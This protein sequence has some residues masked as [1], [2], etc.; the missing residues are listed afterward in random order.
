VT[1][2]LW[3]NESDK[4]VQHLRIIDMTVM[5]TGP[6]LTRVLVQ[7]GADVIKVEHLPHGD[8]LR[9]KKNSG[10]FE[11][12]NQ[13]KR[14]LALNLGTIEATMVMKQLVNEADIFIEN[15]KEGVMDG[16][17]LGYDDLSEENPDLL[18]LSLRGFSGNRKVR[19]GHD[20]NF[21]ATSGCGDFFLESGPHYSTQFADIVGGVSIPLIKLLFQLA[22]PR[23]KGKHIVSNNDESFRFLYLPRAYDHFK[24]EQLPP[25]EK[26]EFGW[27]TVLGGDEPHS[28]Y[29][30]CRDDKW[31]ALN[32]VQKNHWEKFCDVV[33]KSD[34]KNRLSDPNLTSEMQKLFLDAPSTYWE[35][36][37]SKNEICLTK[38]VSWDELIAS[39]P[40][41]Q[42]LEGD[43]LTW[44][45]LTP[46][47]K[48]S[49]APVLGRDTLSITQG[50][51]FTNREIAEWL[52]KKI[53]FQAS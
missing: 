51:G 19:S 7:Y 52:D 26:E 32:A 47:P 46:N 10:F 9:E 40:T 49:A 4:P 43:P 36:I 6:L 29:Y 33:D 22:S 21:I 31:V 16:F 48:L 39:T 41:R 17:D 15:F 3:G 35:T 27:Q 25:H 24:S 11:L 2:P 18:Y 50:I 45:G 20:L 5:L 1:T 44:C 8:H 38:V 42:Q 23:Q 37:A 53:L 34:W 28:R 12:L 30:K 14:S 13:G